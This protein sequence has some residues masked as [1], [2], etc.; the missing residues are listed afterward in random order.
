MSGPFTK[1]AVGKDDA[2][3][4]AYLDLSHT[5][6]ALESGAPHEIDVKALADTLD[7]IRETYAG[8]Q[9]LSHERD[10]LAEQEGNA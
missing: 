10:A 3:L 8:E 5:L 4:R 7:D 1:T 2:L 9:D 6:M